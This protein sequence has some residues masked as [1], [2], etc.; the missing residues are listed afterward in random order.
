MSASYPAPSV[1]TT[2]DKYFALVGSLLLALRSL[3]VKWLIIAFYRS[4]ILK[5]R[6]NFTEF[7]IASSFFFF[8]DLNFEFMLLLTHNVFSR[9]NLFLKKR[10][11][12]V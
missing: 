12:T 10:V 1:S 7:S 5:A 9:Q 8:G 6:A 3:E 2:P 4:V 11:A